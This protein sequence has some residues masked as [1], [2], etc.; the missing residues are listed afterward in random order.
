[1]KNCAGWMMAAMLGFASAPSWAADGAYRQTVGSQSTGGNIATDLSTLTR[2]PGLGRAAR[3]TRLLTVLAQQIPAAGAAP[4]TRTTVGDDNTMVQAPGWLLDVRGDGNWVRFIADSYATNAGIPTVEVDARMTTAELEARARQFISTVLAD[5]VVLGKGET[6]EVWRTSYELELTGSGDAA[7]GAVQ[8]KVAANKIVFT[9]ALGQVPLLG[10]GSKVSVT[11]A[12]DGAV[13]GFQYDWSAIQN[14]GA[15]KHSAVA[16]V[17]NAR[18]NALLKSHGSHVGLTRLECG[19]YDTGAID[20]SSL[21][22][23]EA[24]CV[25]ES[26]VKQ[27]G[28]V[29][30]F[31]DAVPASDVVDSDPAWPET[32]SITK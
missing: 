30:A 19:Y 8:K 9:R 6:L 10:P 32:L 3:V 2:V 28:T 23:I 20:P 16:S 21:G 15:T 27:S 24:G 29:A 14:T 1:M 25:A 11:F 5:Q 31:V 18:L 26:V 4:S 17:V 7:P 22:K 13:T 12:N